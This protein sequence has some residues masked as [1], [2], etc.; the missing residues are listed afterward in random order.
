MIKVSDDFAKVCA[1]VFAGDLRESV[2]LIHGRP[3][4]AKPF[5][6]SDSQV[7]IAAIHPALS[8]GTWPRALME[9]AGWCLIS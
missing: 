8:C 7:E 1:R 3:L 6:C 5:L 4:I 9:Y 2:V